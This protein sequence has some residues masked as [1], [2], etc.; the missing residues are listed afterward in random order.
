MR[1]LRRLAARARGDAERGRAL[2]GAA[3]ALQRASADLVDVLLAA[4]PSLD[5]FDAAAVGRTR[6]LEELLD[7]RAGARARLVAGRLHARSTTRRSSA[8][9]RRRGSCSSAERR[10]GVVARNESI[11]VTPL[12]SAAAGGARRD[13]QA[14][15]R[16]RRRPERGP[17]RRLHAAPLGRSERRSRERRGAARRRRRPD[18]RRTTRARRPPSSPA[19]ACATYSAE[20]SSIRLPHGSATRQRR[21]P[22]I[23]SSS[24]TST[25][26]ARRRS[27]S[28]S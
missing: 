12:H 27:S 20:I 21:T 4:N 7:R 16:A 8:R 17:G 19:T 1:G 22:G 14:A 11:H 18:A 9:R 28:S 10:S 23:A 15:A 5:V 25:P 26:A 6:G 13:R 2:A 24:A 3:G